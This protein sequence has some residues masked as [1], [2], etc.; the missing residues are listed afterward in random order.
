MGTRGEKD[1]ERF[2][3]TRFDGRDF[4]QTVKWVARRS[5]KRSCR[6]SVLKEGLAFQC[7]ANEFEVEVSREMASGR[8]RSGC[9]GNGGTI[10]WL[11]HSENP[12]S[13]LVAFCSFAA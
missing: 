12:F 3:G 6:N 4:D 9:H 7:P 8:E 13:P 10:D 11:P 1:C 2:C 5:K